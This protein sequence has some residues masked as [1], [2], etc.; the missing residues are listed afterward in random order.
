MGQQVGKATIVENVQPFVNLPRV[1]CQRLWESFHDV[2]EGFGLQLDELQEICYV[3][4]RVMA[5]EKDQLDVLVERLFRILDTDENGLIDA[6]ETQVTMCALSSM[7]I[8][9]KAEF[10]FNCFDFDESGRISLDETTLLFRQ[11]LSGTAKASASMPPHEEAVANIAAEI[12]RRNRSDPN[13]GVGP[14][15]QKDGGWTGTMTDLS[16]DENAYIS[17]AEFVEFCDTSPEVASWMGHYDDLPDFF[18]TPASSTSVN[19]GDATKDEGNVPMQEVRVAWG[20]DPEFGTMGRAA[21]LPGIFQYFF[22]IFCICTRYV[23]LTCIILFHGLFLSPF[24]LF[25]FTNKIPRWSW[26]WWCRCRWRRRWT[27][28]WRRRRWTRWR[29]E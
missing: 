1:A 8:H 12:F 4:D 2:A 24:F 19:F 27:R 16:S 10:M 23:N 3:L 13:S 14:P 15:D 28:R 21:A 18:A 26:W 17:K 7:S 9:E 20:T 22:L 29:R 25:L 6:L 5:T 11:A